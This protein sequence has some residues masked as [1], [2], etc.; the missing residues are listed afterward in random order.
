MLLMLILVIA[1]LHSHERVGDNL[2]MHV[3]VLAELTCVVSVA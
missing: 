3:R 1:A 2:H